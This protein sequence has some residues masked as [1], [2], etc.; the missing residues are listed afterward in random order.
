MPVRCQP[1][2]TMERLIVSEDDSR[3]AP[4]EI[5]LSDCSER[6]RFHAYFRHQAY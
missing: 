2:K 6:N 1:V 3:S 4:E 5:Y